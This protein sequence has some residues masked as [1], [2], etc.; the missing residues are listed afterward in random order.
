MVVAYI[1]YASRLA[2]MHRVEQR[3]EDVVVSMTD[4]AD[5]QLFATSQ[6]IRE[7]LTQGGLKLENELI[8]SVDA[9]QISQYVARNG[10]VSGADVYATYS[11]KLYINVRQHKPTVRLLC[12][13]LNSYATPEGNIF[14]SP[15]G[16]A[17]YTSVVTGCY[18][19]P[20]ALNYEG[21]VSDS[22]T[23]VI[24]KVDDKQKELAVKFAE[25]RR[26]RRE[27][28]SEKSRLRKDRGRKFWEN[29]ESYQQRRVGVE[30][31][32]ERCNEQIRAIASQ[33]ADLEKQQGRVEASKKKLQKRYDDFANLIN[34]VTQISDDSFWGAEVVQFVA[35][36]TLLGDISLRLVPRSGNF[37]IEFGTLENSQEKL[38]KLRFFYDKGLSRLGWE[39]FRKIDVRYD[40]QVICAE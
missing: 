40:K 12:G 8:D 16:S 26:E 11:G 31:D 38:D 9:V 33:R 37:I 13:G 15:E 3:V 10:F 4:S 35:D 1:C 22:R 27:L 5:M 20:F 17:Y 36:T 32:I 25:L 34:F 7:Q 24:A 29:K 18:K 14:L 39:R 6:Q 19:V 21:E 2:K 23:A 30:A 28:V